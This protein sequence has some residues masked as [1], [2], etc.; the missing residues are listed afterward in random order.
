MTILVT[1][2]TGFLGA[3]LMEELCAA[4]Q[5]VYGF[6]INPPPQ[7]LINRLNQ[8]GF[9]GTFYI[10][11]TRDTTAVSRAIKESGATQIIH[12]ATVTADEAR[13][14]SA[15]QQVLSVN[16]LGIAALF[17]AARDAGVSRV[18]HTSSNAAYGRNVFQLEP[19]V[20]TTPSDPVSLYEIT[21]FAG[22]RT[23]LRLGALYGIDV[24]V[25]RLSTVF[26]PWERATGVRD[27]LS[28]M[29]QVWNLAA[30][31]HE[32]VLPRPGHRDWIY[33]RDAATAIIALL[34]V[35]LETPKI[36]NI[37]P[38]SANVWSVLAWGKAV[39]NKFPGFQCRVAQN[40]EIPNI[41]LYQSRD[42]AALDITRLS[43]ATGFV[44][45]YD[46]DAALADY[47]KFREGFLED[48]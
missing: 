28:P 40:G 35:V 48:L 18:I 46:M 39:A 34:S 20:E 33:V 26:G 42:R 6:D 11:D 16:I 22:E 8:L 47:G 45:K 37:G 2:A 1:G 9:D 27:T 19:I 41:N 3:S 31:G 7:A 14:A 13:D 21:K 29:L 23:A 38:G 24:R 15:P 44:P 12:A 10:G 5:H 4:K 36:F 43:K 25:A 32:A 30:S 17:E